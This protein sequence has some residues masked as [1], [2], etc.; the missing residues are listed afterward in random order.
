[1]NSSFADRFG[2]VC[3]DYTG[4]KKDVSIIRVQLAETDHSEAED[5]SF[6]IH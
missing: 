1:M 4:S 5:F 3:A 2:I 6:E